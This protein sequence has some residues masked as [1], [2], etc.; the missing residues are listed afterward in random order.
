M[1]FITT[2]RSNEFIINKK[3]NIILKTSWGYTDLAKDYSAYPDV[4]SN[5]T[6]EQWEIGY[7]EW[8]DESYQN[9]FY[10]IGI[11]FALSK[12][13]KGAGW[14]PEIYYSNNGFNLVNASTVELA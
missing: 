9:F 12:K 2:P 8:A 1:N 5:S 4:P 14:S 11:Q 7:N 10:K 3:K 6:F 13:N